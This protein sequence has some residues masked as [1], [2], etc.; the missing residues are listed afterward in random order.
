MRLKFFIERKRVLFCVFLSALM[1]IIYH[2]STVVL[3]DT[4]SVYGSFES[5]VGYNDFI[6]IS[7]SNLEGVLLIFI[8]AFPLV[9]YFVK[10]FTKVETY[11]FTRISSKAL[12]IFFKQMSLLLYG[13]VST[14][15][16]FLVKL[17]LFNQ[18]LNIRNTLY[19]FFIFYFF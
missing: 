5:I 13:F 12:F 11:I 14:A 4:N 9:N 16:Y 15:I 19:C 10:D 6:E 2:F 17:I 8:L 7:V 1:G 3:S 18:P